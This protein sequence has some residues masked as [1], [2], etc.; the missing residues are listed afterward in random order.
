MTTYQIEINE[1]QRKLIA[2]VLKH[3]CRSLENELVNEDSDGTG[4]DDNALEAL[5][6]LTDMFS[7]LNE[8][9]EKDM[10]HGFC[11]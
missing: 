8:N 5:K 6:A 3:G 2:R 1:Y 9:D 7:E 4:F 11:F 10:I